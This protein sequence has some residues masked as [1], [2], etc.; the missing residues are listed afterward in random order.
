MQ[1]L[2][3][4]SMNTVMRYLESASSVCERLSLVNER[5]SLVCKRSKFAD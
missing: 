1:F 2:C 4:S 5:L 3:S